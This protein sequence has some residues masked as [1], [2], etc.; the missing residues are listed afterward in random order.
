MKYEW[1]TNALCSWH[2]GLLPKIEIAHLCNER[3]TFIH[4]SVKSEPSPRFSSQMKS[5]THPLHDSLF[6]HPYDKLYRIPSHSCS[7]IGARMYI[8]LDENLKS[9]KGSITSRGHK[10]EAWKH[11]AGYRIFAKKRIRFF[12]CEYVRGCAFSPAV[13]KQSVGLRAGPS[14]PQEALLPMQRCAWTPKDLRIT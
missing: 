7:D 10:N 4:Q 11:L 12:F 14:G 8:R 9:F 13:C 6:C 5:A 1:S 3:S 2:I